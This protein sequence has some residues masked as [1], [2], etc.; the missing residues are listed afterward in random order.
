[1]NVRG[2]I[3]DTFGSGGRVSGSSRRPGRHELRLPLK[4]SVFFGTLL[5]EDASK[6]CHHEDRM[7]TATFE[8]LR[9]GAGDGIT[10]I[11]DPLLKGEL[12]KCFQ[13]LELHV[14]RPDASKPNR[15]AL[16]VA[17]D[18][19]PVGVSFDVYV[20]VKGKERRVGFL[21]LP[22]K[23][24]QGNWEMGCALDPPVPETLDVIFRSSKA[25]ARETTDVLEMWDGE[26]VFESV[27]V[28]VD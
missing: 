10:L 19:L 25:I 9:P 2:S 17:F 21:A 3:N 4:V 16:V 7:L 26:L 18:P 28:K 22:Q 15:C 20:R 5:D 27:P 14:K 1:V 6:L 12:L 8:V 13:R 11:Q 23:P 24:E